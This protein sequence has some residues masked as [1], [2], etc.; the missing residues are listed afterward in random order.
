M[1]KSIVR[2]CCRK[3]LISEHVYNSEGN[4]VGLELLQ[5]GIYEYKCA[6]LTESVCFNGKSKKQE[7]E[8]EE[9]DDKVE[10]KV[11]EVK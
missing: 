6:R 5:R 4:F 2:Y 9:G 3:H 10:Q 8:D 1:E 11:K 7:E